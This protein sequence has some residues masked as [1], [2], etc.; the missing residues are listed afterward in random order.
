MID[1]LPKIIPWLQAYP[2]WLQAVVAGWAIL[3]TL[4]LVMLLLIP[5]AQDKPHAPTEKIAP[6][7]QKIEQA[8]G[9]PVINQETKGD[10]SPAVQGVDGDVNIRIEQRRNKK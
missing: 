1:T 9:L 8:P 5:R 2:M 7:E 6:N 3:T 10:N 4:I